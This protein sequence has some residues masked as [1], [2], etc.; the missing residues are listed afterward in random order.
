[1]PDWQ[2]SQGAAQVCFGDEPCLSFQNASAAIARA[3]GSWDALLP[4]DESRLTGNSGENCHLCNGSIISPEG[5]M[6][7]VSHKRLYSYSHTHPREVWNMAG[8][9]GRLDE[10]PDPDQLHFLRSAV[11]DECRQKAAVAPPPP[12]S[13]LPRR[14]RA[15]GPSSSHLPTHCRSGYVPPLLPSQVIDVSQ[16]WRSFRRGGSPPF[17]LPCSSARGEDAAVLRSFFS[18]AA[19]GA[20]LRGGR[21]LEI[22]GVDGLVESNTWVL[23]RCLGWRGVLVEGHPLYFERLRRQ[24]PNSLNV[25]L[26]ACARE[27]WARYD[28]H[29]WTGAKVKS[30]VVEAVGRVGRRTALTECA[31]LGARLRQLGVHRLDLVSV[32]VEGAEVHVVRS[33]ANVSSQL[34]IGVMLIEARADGN[35]YQ[36]MHALL[37]VGFRYVGQLSAR[38]SESNDVVDDCFVNVTH[39]R[40]YFPQS[41]ALQVASPGSPL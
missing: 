41:R 3:G 10:L 2:L 22:G 1:M 38:G 8:A 27:G 14:R 16:G 30:G 18:D 32:D 36:L 17:F 7:D 37:A 31:P 9:I 39:L 40:T 23:E 15:A 6:V 4:R 12:P 19:S 20:P 11:L 21:F 35:R 33:L 5:A 25:H 28:I 26:A 13:P 24:R 34:S 29:M